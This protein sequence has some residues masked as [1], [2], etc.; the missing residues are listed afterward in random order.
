MKICIPTLDD[1]GL[2]SRIS[3]HFGSAQYLTLINT[4]GGELATVRNLECRHQ[5]HSCH[6]LDSLTSLGV[7]AL[8][9]VGVGRRAFSALQEAGIEVLRTGHET[10]GDIL[11]ELEAGAVQPLTAREACGGRHARGHG[12]GAGRSDGACRHE[13]GNRRGGEEPHSGPSKERSH[14][15]RR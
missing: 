12:A 15:E 10:V 3:N 1:R 14:F 2:E 8:V 11:A 6:H 7:E 9:C 13:P 5:L 4:E